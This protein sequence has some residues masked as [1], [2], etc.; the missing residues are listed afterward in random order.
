MTDALHGRCL[1]GAVTLDVAHH[2]GAVGACHCRLCQRWGGVFLAFEA[3]EAEVTVT[4]E[5]RTF[6]STPFSER[7][8]CPVCGTHL[9]LRDVGNPTLDLMPG[10][11]DAAA[12]FPLRSEVYADRAMASVRLAGDHPRVTRA[13]YEARHLHLDGDTP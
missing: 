10:P 12:A 3:D 1:C 11:F 6:P 13:D 9:W 4:G 2:D 7:A 5:V 8:F